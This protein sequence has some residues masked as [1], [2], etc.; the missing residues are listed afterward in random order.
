MLE[1]LKCSIILGINCGAAPT[2]VHRIVPQLLFN[3]DPEA[4][5]VFEV[6]E[7]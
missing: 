6:L 4:I 1:S 2:C 5:T 3:E 7:D